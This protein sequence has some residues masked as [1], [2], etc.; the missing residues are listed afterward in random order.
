MFEHYSESAR[1]TIYRAKWEATRLGSREIG[2][3][4]ILLGLFGDEAL[5]HAAFSGGTQAL[6]A[7]ILSLFP[8]SQPSPLP[9]DLPLSSEGKRALALGNEEADATNAG[10]VENSHILLGLLRFEGSP[11]SRLL[12]KN[13][14]SVEVVRNL[15]PPTNKSSRLPLRVQ[16]TGADS[17]FTDIIKKAVQ[18]TGV[19]E[20]SKALALLD[21]AMTK[22]ADDWQ[23]RSLA[24]LATIISRSSG[25]LQL[26]RSYCERR[27][28]FDPE[29]TR[30]LYQLADC[31]AL[32]GDWQ[33]ARQYAIKSYE[34]SIAKG[35]T[36]G[37]KI[38]TLIERR[39]PEIKP[40]T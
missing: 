26:M 25:N 21:D 7:E 40:N 16:A 29:D 5:V 10:D 17:K 2:P 1:Q 39:F 28:A 33:L 27:L 19:G 38:R 32:L 8:Q 37:R 3:E 15:W 30:A 22:S 35:E 9:I 36:E 18:L 31:L 11:V 12:K 24:D 20:N 14:L 4:H 23:V 6:Q 13:G 34:L